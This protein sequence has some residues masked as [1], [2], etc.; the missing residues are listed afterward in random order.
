M[1]RC[2]CVLKLTDALKSKLVISCESMGAQA[3]TVVWTVQ[4]FA[5]RE[6][7]Q[8]RCNTVAK[9]KWGSGYACYW[10]WVGLGWVGLLPAAKWP[11]SAAFSLQRDD[12][13]YVPRCHP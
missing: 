1:S 9:A 13:I 8:V 2:C 12:R 6:D 11:L 5:R 7:L 3:P 4:K 10:V